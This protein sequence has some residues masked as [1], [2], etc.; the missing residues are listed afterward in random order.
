MDT[1]IDINQYYISVSDIDGRGVEKN[2]LLF[3]IN[4]MSQEIRLLCELF[5]SFG[6]KMYTFT[7]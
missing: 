1:N 2:N 4:I 6:K 7:F 5:Y 3:I